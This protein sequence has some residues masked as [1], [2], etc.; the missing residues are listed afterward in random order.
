MGWIKRKMI[1]WLFGDV[2]AEL[3]MDT[4]NRIDSIIKDIT[5]GHIPSFYHDNK[6]LV[7]NFRI[8]IR[9]I[10]VD[11]VRHDVEAKVSKEVSEAVDKL[12]IYKESFLD[13]V[14]RRLKAKQIK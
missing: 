14:V 10:V 13:E 1:S 7:S 8:T 6:E 9:S 11:Y 12:E 3:K 2:M 5:K 4:A